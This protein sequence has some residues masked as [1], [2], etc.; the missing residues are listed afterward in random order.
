MF[1]ISHAIEFVC[2]K[3]P[4]TRRSTEPHLKPVSPQKN[5]CQQVL[6]ELYWEIQCKLLYKA[7]ISHTN[8][9][10]PPLTHTLLA[11]MGLD[12]KMKLLTMYNVW[13]WSSCLATACLK[14]RTKSFKVSQCTGE[15]CSVPDGQLCSWMRISSSRSR[16]VKY[17]TQFTN[18][19][20]SWREQEKLYNCVWLF[21]CKYS[22]KGFL[23][24]M[25]E[26]KKPYPANRK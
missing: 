8:Y 11:G 16:D 25:R 4:K 7:H 15:L 1:I 10:Q 2:R 13:S 18:T 3:K 20:G 24:H 17:S 9:Q 23:F 6:K 5:I 12:M 19:W 14:R 22:R 21:Q 26:P